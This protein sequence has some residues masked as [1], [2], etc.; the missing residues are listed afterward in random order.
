MLECQFGMLE[1]FQFFLGNI[2]LQLIYL[3]SYGKRMKQ[4]ISYIQ[5][6]IKIVYDLTAFKLCFFYI[7][8]MVGAGFVE[9][10]LI[11]PLQKKM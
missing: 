10:L 5:L 2:M 6:Q 4:F 11:I 7:N 8:S 9:R 1:C 3:Y